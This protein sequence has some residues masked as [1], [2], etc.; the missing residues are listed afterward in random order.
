MKKD[1]DK[2]KEQ[3]LSE[4]EDMHQRI[5]QLETLED[6]GVHTKTTIS[7]TRTDYENLYGDLPI[8]ITVLDVKGMILYCNPIVYSIGVGNQ[9]NGT[10]FEPNTF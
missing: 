1:Q 4:L 3:L 8:G 6:E 5:A 10:L 7:V 2:T 9:Q